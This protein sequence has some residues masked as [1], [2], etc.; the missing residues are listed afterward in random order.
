MMIEY[1]MSVVE[2]WEKVMRKE[3]RIEDVEEK[4]YICIEE[5]D[6]GGMIKKLK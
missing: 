5:L 1:L 6:C 4:F 3:M 2:Y